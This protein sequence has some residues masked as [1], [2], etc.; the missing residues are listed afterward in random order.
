MGSLHLEDLVWAGAIGGDRI[1][2]QDRFINSNQA[3]W[4]LLRRGLHD[5]SPVEGAASDEEVRA[6]RYSAACD[7]QIFDHVMNVMDDVCIPLDILL[8]V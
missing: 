2:R 4:G 8:T 1:V 6:M 7:A 5:R 3:L